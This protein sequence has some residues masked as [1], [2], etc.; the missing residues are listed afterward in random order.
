MSQ[1]LVKKYPEIFRVR[2]TEAQ[3]KIAVAK[4]N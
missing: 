3:M 1:S 2:L 4:I